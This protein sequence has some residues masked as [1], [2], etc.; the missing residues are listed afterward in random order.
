MALPTRLAG[1]ALA[2]TIT[3]S[4]LAQTPGL[5]IENA[6]PQLDANIRALVQLPNQACDSEPGSLGRFLPGIRRQI[7]RAGRALGYYFLTERTRFVQG[8]TCWEL[9]TTIE[10]GDPITIASVEVNVVTDSELFTTEVQELPVREG[11]QLNHALYE[12][13]KSELSARAVE[14]GF[15]AA[16][17]ASS[18][19]QLDLQQNIAHVKIEFEPGPRS[20]FGAVNIEPVAGLSEDFIRRFVSFQTDTFYSASAL[21]DLRNVLNDSF[22]FSNVTVTPDLEQAVDQ[23]MPVQVGLQLRPRRVYSTGVGV[24]TDIGPRLRFDYEDRYVNRSGHQFNARTAASPIQQFV[25]LEYAIPWSDPATERLTFSGG[26]LHE[27]NDSFILETT[28]IGASYSYLNRWNWRQNYFLNFQHDNSKVGDSEE[29]SDMLIP[30][31][32]LTRTLADDALYPQRGWTLFGQLMGASD[33]LLST[34]TF[35]QLNARGKAITPLGPGR[36]IVKLEAGTTVTDDI[37]NLPASIQYFTGGDQSVR[38]YKYRSLAPVDDNGDLAGGKHLLV[39][40]IEYDFNI[41]PAWKLAVFADAG[42]AFT[43][44]ND[45]DLQKSVGIG[46]RWMSPLGPIRVDIASALDDD[47]KIRLHLTMGPD[48]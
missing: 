24:T 25:D 17:F 13:S 26:F 27:D 35:L 41:L 28:K 42:N 9:Q 5:Q 12:R 46:V 34:E 10:P 33:S 18:E 44:F 38:G 11:D 16:R 39:G 45:Y 43:D 36:V 6:P 48:L 3:P 7:S 4:A 1:L 21:I 47:N 22:Y 14:L 19:L 30:G 2:L 40:G 29:I 31:M 32:S 8:E 15:F 23:R 20:Q 37:T